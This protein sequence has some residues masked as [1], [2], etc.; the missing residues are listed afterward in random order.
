M[1]KKQYHAEVILLCSW[2]AQCCFYQCNAVLGQWKVTAAYCSIRQKCI[3]LTVLVS[4]IPVARNNM[5]W[6]CLHRR[7]SN[8][9]AKKFH[10]QYL[11]DTLTSTRQQLG[12]DR[13]QEQ[14]NREVA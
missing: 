12:D 4:V 5:P 8:N 1:K 9:S 3:N 6:R 2:V 7:P 13:F 11:E 10:G 14:R